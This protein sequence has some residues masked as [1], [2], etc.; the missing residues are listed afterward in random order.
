L[1]F[2]LPERFRWAGA[3]ELMSIQHGR[4]T[5]PRRGGG[6]A[7]RSIAFW[8]CSVAMKRTITRGRRARS[9]WRR[10]QRQDSF[11]AP[12]RCDCTYSRRTGRSTRDEIDAKRRH[13]SRPTKRRYPRV[14]GREG[15]GDRPLTGRTFFYIDL[16]R[17]NQ[18][19]EVNAVLEPEPAGDG[20]AVDLVV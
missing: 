1:S 15:R 7:R 2:L 3:F 5:T 9:K 18:V 12:I 6:A 13:A 16:R 14:S 4:C 20:G 8:F 11:A 10:R 17:G 19:I